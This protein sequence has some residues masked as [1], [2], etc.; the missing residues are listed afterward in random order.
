METR[1]YKLNFGIVTIKIDGNKCSATYMDNA[2]FEGTIDG[3]IVKAQWKNE[4]KEGLIELDLSD[5]K[6]VGKWKQG[7]EEGPMRGKW[8]GKLINS[9]SIPQDVTEKIIIQVN[10]IGHEIVQ[11][12]FTDN[13]IEILQEES[14]NEGNDIS[15]VMEYVED[16]LDEELAWFDRDDLYHKYGACLDDIN[17]KILSVK[18]ELENE[19]FSFDSPYDIE[20][21]GGET[22]YEEIYNSDGSKNVVTTY[23]VD[24]G[25]LGDYE[26]ILKQNE[27]F[28]LS[29]LKFVLHDVLFGDYDISYLV[30]IYYDN[31]SL[32]GDYIDTKAIDFKSYLDM[33]K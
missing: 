4:G 20:E 14:F 29:K 3:D 18:N 12:V 15:D 32:I 2:S 24:K 22:D 7:L 27:Q 11:G 17:I 5:N 26:I 16:I 31:Q 1:E 8:E 9:E 10:G 21:Y 13:E 28:E 6:L 30:D 33:K 25:A 23:R 19:L